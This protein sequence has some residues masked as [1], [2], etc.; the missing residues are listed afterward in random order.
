MDSSQSK[1][2][3]QTFDFDAGHRIVKASQVDDPAL[4]EMSKLQRLYGA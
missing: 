1:V 4:K 3:E 2:A